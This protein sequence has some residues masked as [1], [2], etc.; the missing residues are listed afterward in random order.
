MRVFDGLW[1]FGQELKLVDARSAEGR[2]FR[3]FLEALGAEDFD[4]RSPVGLVSKERFRLIAEPGEKF[5]C[6][7]ETV[8]F[9]R[10]MRYGILGIREI[11]AGEGISH[12]ELVL[13]RQG[14]VDNE[15]L[16]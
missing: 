9:F 5:P 7:R 13:S 14:E 12:R 4:L 6:G 16:R 8:I 3:G 1:A 15:C 11:Y 10:G 2:W